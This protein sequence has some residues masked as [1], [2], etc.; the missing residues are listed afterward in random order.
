MGKGK[1]YYK[2]IKLSRNKNFEIQFDIGWCFNTAD[3]P[4]RLSLEHKIKQCH[5]G[6][7]IN[8]GLFYIF[9]LIFSFYDSR[10]WNYEENR[11]YHPGEEKAQLSIT[12]SNLEKLNFYLHFNNGLTEIYIHNDKFLNKDNKLIPI[13]TVRIDRDKNHY[14]I[15][16][17]NLDILYTKNVKYINDIEDFINFFKR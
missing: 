12:R 6:L 17:K 13:Y 4:F 1:S 3:S 7:I 15:T 9:N 2:G 8:F 11:F 14:N 5:P 10:H 16:Y